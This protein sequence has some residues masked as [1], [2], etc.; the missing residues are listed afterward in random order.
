[1][2][3][4][5]IKDNFPVKTLQDREYAIRQELCPECG[6]KL[7]KDPDARDYKYAD[8][9]CSIDPSHFRKRLKHHLS[10]K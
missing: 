1:M 4:Q 8:T 10:F 3:E 7:I 2:T 9:I 6:N 5:F